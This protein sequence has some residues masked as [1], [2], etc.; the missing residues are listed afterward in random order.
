MTTEALTEK[1][2][3]AVLRRRAMDY[4]ARREHSRY[5]LEQKLLE[6]FPDADL[7]VMTGVLDKLVAD[8]LLSDQRFAESYVRSRVS[9]G[10]G[11]L[12]IRYQLRQRQL[13]PALIDAQITLG[14]EDWVDLLVDVLRRKSGS[15][16]DQT[17]PE[18][19]SKAWQKL[20]RFSQS[21]GFT[22]EHFARA[23]RRR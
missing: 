22:M 21:R 2:L 17:F 7:S 10:Y 13:D 14:D 1:E 11:P 6:K 15:T 4:L 19:G 16:L 12:Y 18:R 20:Q 5:E 8:R 3:S 9:K 23:S